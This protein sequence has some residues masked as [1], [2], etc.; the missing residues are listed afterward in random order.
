M[1][2]VS[3]IVP[4]YNVEA[5][6]RCCVDS[7]LAQTFTDFEL[8]LVDDGSSDKSG[9]ICDE[10]A[11]Q[12]ARVIVLH[13]KNGGVSAA[14][15]A[16]IDYVMANCDSQWIAFVDS[17]DWIHKS[18]L[19]ILLEAAQQCSVDIAQ[20]DSQDIL[21]GEVEKTVDENSI[22]WCPASPS[23][24]Y[25]RPGAVVPMRK[26]IRKHLLNEIRF[27]NGRI[28]ED[29]AVMH[30]VVFAVNQVAIVDAP[31]YCYRVRQGSIMHSPWSVKRLDV[32]EAI[33]DQLSYF[34]DK[35]I[36]DMYERTKKKYI[37]WITGLYYVCAHSNDPKKKKAL[38]ILSG[39]M[40]NALIRYGKDL[41]ISIKDDL[42]VFE[43]AF[44][45]IMWVYWCIRA[46]LEKLKNRE[47]N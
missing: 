29:E 15:N 4:V 24:A 31:L 28:H 17:D 13:Q 23:E 33:E 41:G 3:V 22:Q 47:K 5:Y 7:I 36:S 8:F 39:R 19:S 16:G 1:A 46:R 6:L 20:C 44:P 42:R 2:K 30:R 40:R 11:A 10:Y 32:L 35:Q 26:I 18:Y 34:A 25:L 43:V 45:R 38:R 12:D 37:D 9:E 21:D 27:P 14:R